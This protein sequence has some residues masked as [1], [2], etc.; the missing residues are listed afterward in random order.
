MRKYLNFFS[1]YYFI[2][3]RDRDSFIAIMQQQ[4]H[5][6]FSSISSLGIKFECS[7]RNSVNFA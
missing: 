4:E 3:G 6:H 1:T 7:L 2:A 5:V